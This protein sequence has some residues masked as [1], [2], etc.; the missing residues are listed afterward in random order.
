MCTVFGKEL[1]YLFYGGVFYRPNNLPTRN[2]TESPIAF[3]FSPAII[4]DLFKIFP[5]DTGAL[6]AGKYGHWSTRLTPI[7]IYEAL[8]TTDN[9][10]ISKLVYYMFGENDLYLRGRP[11]PVSSTYPPPFPEVYDFYIDDLT[12][13]G[14]DR[15]QCLIE[16]QF[17]SPIPFNESLLWVGFPESMTPEYG[18]LLDLID[19]HKPQFHPYPAEAIF[20]PA[21][22]TAQLEKIARMEVIE[23]YIKYP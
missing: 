10:I 15:R 18:K 8:N 5:F 20:N 6:A 13:L 9:K 17:D 3:V 23:R 19:P 4:K 12:P 7:E 11:N 1:T 14:I 22:V 21:E 16:C 2:P